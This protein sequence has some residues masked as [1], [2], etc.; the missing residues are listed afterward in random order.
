MQP[1]LT[2]S[3]STTSPPTSS[4][5]KVVTV[6]SSTPTHVKSDHFEG[7]VLV[8]IKD[9]KNAPANEASDAY[10]ASKERTGKTWSIWVKGTSV[11]LGSRVFPVDR[12]L[13]VY[14]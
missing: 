4:S 13:F 14:M 7:D 9:Y 12:A 10:F 2:V 11:H 8:R 1:Q 5:S 6:N 3:V